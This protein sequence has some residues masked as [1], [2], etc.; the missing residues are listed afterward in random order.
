[1]FNDKIKEMAR[2]FEMIATEKEK[3]QKNTGIMLEKRPTRR[4]KADSA[5]SVHM[6]LGSIVGWIE[7]LHHPVSI[8]T[9]GIT[10]LRH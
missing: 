5:T 6:L 8:D 10:F 1:M 9:E 3:H 7:L 2:I 4:K